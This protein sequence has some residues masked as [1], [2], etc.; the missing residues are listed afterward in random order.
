MPLGKPNARLEA[1]GSGL[2]QGQ[3]ETDDL[4]EQHA[5]A[6]DVFPETP[7]RLSGRHGAVSSRGLLGQRSIQGRDQRV[8]AD[9]ATILSFADVRSSIDVHDESE[10]T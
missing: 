1:S 7:T 3:P 5:Q 8:I 10:S 9:S 2:F 4:S 6:G